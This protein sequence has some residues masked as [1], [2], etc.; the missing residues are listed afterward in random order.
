VNLTRITPELLR[1]LPVTM[2]GAACEWC[3]KAQSSWCVETA[4]GDEDQVFVC[5][6]C[7]VSK[8]EWSAENDDVLASAT[9]EIGE[10]RAQKLDLGRSDHADHVLGLVVLMSRLGSLRALAGGS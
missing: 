7:V 5:S 6:C 2:R 4:L 1:P 3:S 8:T 10:S 9:Q